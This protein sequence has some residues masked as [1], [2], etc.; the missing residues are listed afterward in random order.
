[1]KLS[2]GTNIQRLRRARGL[3][4][5][6]LADA[7][8]VSAAAVSKWETGAACPDLFLLAPLARLLGTDLNQL[9][10]FRPQLTDREAQALLREYRTLYESGRPEEA[11]SLCRNLLHQ[12]PN[13]LWLKFYLAS[14]FLIYAQDSAQAVELLEA[15]AES[16]D[17][18]LR[19]NAAYVLA[20]LLCHGPGQDL[21]RAQKLLDGLS[22]PA[23]DVRALRMSLLAEQAHWDQAE[24]LA[25][26][27][28]QE[29]LS[30]AILC[31]QFLAKGARA[32]GDLA[33][34]R[35]MLDRAEQLCAGAAEPCFSALL[36]VYVVSAA[37]YCETG[38]PE[39]ALGEVEHLAN[40]AE[41]WA[42][43]SGQ[44]SHCRYLLRTVAHSLRAARELD[45]IRGD[46]RFAAA[47]DRLT[48]HP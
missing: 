47:L 31:L 46:P 26:D 7:V 18:T 16:E 2:I 17:E 27:A 1:M 11:A 34:A 23:L 30:D 21:E 35:E 24:Q 38:E 33:R 43:A 40:S 5:E 39:Q 10:D 9:M 15:C 45:P 42:A 3:T 36:S 19:A 29:H 28:L 41:A 37:L 32:R 6:Q 20:G 12:Y 44:S 13:D 22:F 4:Q 25:G 8:G 48:S 14:L